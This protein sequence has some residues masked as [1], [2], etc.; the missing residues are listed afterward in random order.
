MKC[1]FQKFNKPLEAKFFT[2]DFDNWVTKEN[3][4]IGMEVMEEGG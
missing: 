1:L 2:T 4:G 3:S